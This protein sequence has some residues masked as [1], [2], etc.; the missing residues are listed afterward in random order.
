MNKSPESNSA[1]NE[2]HDELRQ[3]LWE[4]SYGLL[5]DDASAALRAQIKSDPAIAR[6]YSEVRLQAELVG[7]AARVADSSLQ[8]LAGPDSTAAKKNSRSH[9]KTAAGKSWQAEQRGFGTN[10]LAVGGTVALLLL[11]AFGLYQPQATINSVARVDYLVTQITAPANT[12]EGVTQ[13]VEITTTDVHNNGQPA[14]LEVRLV[15][16]AGRETFRKELQT[17][18]NGRGAVEL[19]GSM[20]KPGVRVEATPSE[21]KSNARA[22]AVVSADLQ[23]TEEKKRRLVLL[24]K[25]SAKPGETVGFSMLEIGEYSKRLAAPITDELM[26]ENGAGV[27]VVQPTWETDRQSGVIRGQFALPSNP[28]IESEQLAIRRRSASQ[29]QLA[30]SDDGRD[31]ARKSDML[32]E[33]QELP[34]ERADLRSANRGLANGAATA[35]AF[36]GNAF[37]GNA[38]SDADSLRLQRGAAAEMKMAAPGGAGG[39]AGNQPAAPPADAPLASPPPAPAA[40]PKP[41]AAPAAPAAEI[42]LPGVAMADRKNMEKALADNQTN[43]AAAPQA[44]NA[45]AGLLKSQTGGSGINARSLEQAKDKQSLPTGGDEAVEG[46]ANAL[47][48]NL[49]LGKGTEESFHEAQESFQQQLPTELQV[50]AD[51]QKENLVL[52]ARGADGTVLARREL[53]AGRKLNPSDLAP[54]VAGRLEIELY[55]EGNLSQPA[56]RQQ[57]IR[58]AVQELRFHIEGLKESYAPGEKVQLQVRVVDEQGQPATKASVGVRVWNEV[59]AAAAKSPLL[60]VDALA[61]EEE[62]SAAVQLAALAP[63]RQMKR[64][65]EPEQAKSQEQSQDKATAP[66]EPLLAASGGP[67]AAELNFEASQVV[68]DNRATVQQEYEA[69]LAASQVEHFARI[70]AIGRLLV[71]AGAAVMLLIGLLLIVRSQ[72]KTAA[73][74]PAVSIAAVCLA[75]GLAWYVPPQPMGWELARVEDTG[76]VA[77]PSAE[78]LPKEKQSPEVSPVEP[79]AAAPQP[80]VDVAVEAM[81]ESAPAKPGEAALQGAATAEKAKQLRTE[82]QLADAKPAADANLED[83]VADKPQ[84]KKAAEREA[85]ERRQLGGNP[86]EVVPDTLFWRSLSQVG[87]NGLLTIEFHMPAAESEY[88]LLLDAVGSGR[89]GGQQQLL[90]C[91]EP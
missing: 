64:M 75:L 76:A 62:V 3:Q 18:S 83:R 22:A 46:A 48:A 20:L 7:R 47:A 4:L 42:E 33:R 30:K 28:A 74:V 44:A 85:L 70:R 72:L 57:L 53:E 40:F 14:K 36:A 34:L 67:Q 38:A 84:V 8:I 80:G 88:R 24:E 25:P 26:I 91:R 68:A 23:V 55:R 65:A 82:Q 87:E 10:W 39:A 86:L 66:S 15:D 50:P 58:S 41:G 5:E 2:P 6:L 49:P 37:S 90:L 69:A 11:I 27:D 51:L 77:A 59:A 73:W 9:S 35:R 21:D 54:E 32:T 29:D 31:A 52:I 61:R 12:P 79:I 16:A 19:P 45:K 71:W 17:N 1:K 43:S 89:I 63:E 81:K 13:T 60:L 56:Y 78:T